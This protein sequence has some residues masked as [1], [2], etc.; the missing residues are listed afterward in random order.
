MGGVAIQIPWTF[1][2]TIGSKMESA[3]KVQVP[4]TSHD[5]EKGE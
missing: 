2:E 4:L 3:D 5:D 1:S